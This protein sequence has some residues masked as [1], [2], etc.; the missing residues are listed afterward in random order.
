[1]QNLLIRLHK[2]CDAGIKKDRIKNYKYITKINEIYY[3]S[4]K[5]I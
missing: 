4:L 2:Y 1:M 5:E 3:I